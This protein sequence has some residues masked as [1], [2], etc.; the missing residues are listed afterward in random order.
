MGLN[1]IDRTTQNIVAH[2]TR[3]ELIDWIVLLSKRTRNPVRD[4]TDLSE[5]QL[6]GEFTYLWGKWRSMGGDVV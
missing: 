6:K 4:L 2:C 5:A 3:K 1:A